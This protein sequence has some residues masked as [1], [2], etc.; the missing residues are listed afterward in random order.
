MVER[1]SNTRRAAL[2][3]AAGVAAGAGLWVGRDLWRAH[4]TPR[5][6]TVPP[7]AQD[8]GHQKVVYHLS[9]SGGYSGAKHVGWLG[10]MENHYRALAPGALDL[11]VVV[12]GDG[13]DLLTHALTE[14]DLARRIDGL[15]A[16]GAR[17]L[18]CRNT[19][20]GR[21]LDPDKDLYG[22]AREDLIGAGVAEVALLQREGYAYLK[23]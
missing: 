8:F 21:G 18:I 20:I 7:V 3:A 5:Q 12:N 22:V 17:F 1:R 16:K 6:V 2:I 10:N 4:A 23:P 11:V 9:E 13:I 14:P 19:L 15:K